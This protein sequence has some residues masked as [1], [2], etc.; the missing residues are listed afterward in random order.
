MSGF[1]SCRLQHTR[2]PVPS[3]NEV[4]E[5]EVVVFFKVVVVPVPI[6]DGGPERPTRRPDMLK[7]GRIGSCT[8]VTRYRI[9]CSFVR[10]HGVCVSR[11]LDLDPLEC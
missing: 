3:R 8:R 1:H 10:G 4:V 7:C 9:R 5:V 2:E 11:A 6:D